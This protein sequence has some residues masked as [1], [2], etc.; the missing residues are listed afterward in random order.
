MVAE[1]L[2]LDRD[3]EPSVVGTPCD[4]HDLAGFSGRVHDDILAD[5]GHPRCVRL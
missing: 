5:V 2:V 1:R 3:D 4:I